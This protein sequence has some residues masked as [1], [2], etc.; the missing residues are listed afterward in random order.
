M[1]GVC[2]INNELDKLKFSKVDSFS[3][4]RVGSGLGSDLDPTGSDSKFSTF[5]QLKYLNID[6]IV[7]RYIN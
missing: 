5:L 1:K 7:R 3:V 2:V 6:G 4:K